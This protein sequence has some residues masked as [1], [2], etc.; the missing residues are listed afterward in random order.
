MPVACALSEVLFENRFAELRVATC[1]A[2]LMQ[3]LLL[4]ADQHVFL[5]F[6]ALQMNCFVWLWI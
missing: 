6:H 1:F 5:A 3:S 4:I 2:E